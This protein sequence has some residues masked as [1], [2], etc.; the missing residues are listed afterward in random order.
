MAADRGSDEIAGTL[1]AVAPFWSAGVMPRVLGTIRTRLMGSLEQP[2]P[3][4]SLRAALA[5]SV[6]VAGI[7][8]AG[9]VSAA[10]ACDT[11]PRGS[12]PEAVAGEL[13]RAGC[14]NGDIATVR[15]LPAEAA[16]PLVRRVCAFDRQIVVIPREP[17][18][19]ATVVDLVCVYA[20]R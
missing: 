20:P 3:A 15:A 8:V 19:P 2:R 17:R 10:A 14:R 1:R 6:A 16:A 4:S 13:Q 12:T 7:P 18:P 9:V 11:S 5:F